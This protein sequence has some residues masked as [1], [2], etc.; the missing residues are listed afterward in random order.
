MLSGAA[1]PLEPTWNWTMVEVV[2]GT[3]HADMLPLVGSALTHEHTCSFFQEA[4]L[5]DGEG[6]LLLL[7]SLEPRC[8][9]RCRISGS[10]VPRS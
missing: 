3:A 4:S 9:G 1:E 10:L 2:L 6:R 7:N 8:T 5:L